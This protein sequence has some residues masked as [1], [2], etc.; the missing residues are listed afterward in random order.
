MPAVS[1]FKITPRLPLRLLRKLL[2]YPQSSASTSYSLAPLFKLQLDKQLCYTEEAQGTKQL[3][4]WLRPKPP[5]LFW[6]ARAGERRQ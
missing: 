4:R 2:T 3:S 5:A 6:P 1:V